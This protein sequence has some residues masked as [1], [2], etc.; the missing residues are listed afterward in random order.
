MLLHAMRFVILFGIILLIVGWALVLAVSCL[1]WFRHIRL[2][3]LQK[4]HLQ[5]TL[6]KAKFS[7]RRIILK[8]M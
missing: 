5:L 7:R 3:R 1:F 2:F 8:D 6:E 4:I